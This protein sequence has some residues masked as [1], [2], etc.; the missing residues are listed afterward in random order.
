MEINIS[1]ILFQI[2]N[3]GVVM[4]LLN[5]VLYKPLMK[6]LDDRAKKINDGMAAAE[7]NLKASEESEKSKKTEIAKARKEAANIISAAEQDAK[8]KA[9]EI[10]K[11]A[12]Q[13]AKAEIAKL[14]TNAQKEL[15][16]ERAKLQKEASTLASAIAKK[17]LAETLSVKDIETITSKILKS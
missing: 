3:F 14:K 7:K 15:E 13:K 4:Y 17:T 5:R 9:S 8:A 2:F 16:S 1:Q 11:T 12:E 6:M 10:V